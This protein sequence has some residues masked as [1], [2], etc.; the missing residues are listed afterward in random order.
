MKELSGRRAFRRRRLVS[1]SVTGQLLEVCTGSSEVRR[2]IFSA[3]KNIVD[4]LDNVGN[5]T[6]SQS[7]FCSH[8]QCNIL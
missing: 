5:G 1:R 6:V 7:D 4:T 8:V 2:H 3:A